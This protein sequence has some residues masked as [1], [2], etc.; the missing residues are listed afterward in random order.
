MG[1]NWLIYS[2]SP[3]PGEGW[4][5]SSKKVIN[6][7]GKRYA[8]SLIFIETQIDLIMSYCTAIRLAN[9]WAVPRVDKNE[10]DRKPS[11]TDDQHTD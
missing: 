10:R 7:C 8:M 11:F 2:C 5:E 3:E 9:V 1:S 4:A 6:M